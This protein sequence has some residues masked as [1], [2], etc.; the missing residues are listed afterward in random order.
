MMAKR[1]SV[2]ELERDGPHLA[3][4]SINKALALGKHEIVE[5]L[6]FEEQDV[7]IER[8]PK[9]CRAAAPGEKLAVVNDVYCPSG[10]QRP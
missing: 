5:V 7:I 1:Q 3:D 9:P 6:S 8:W 10:F 2:P 4:I